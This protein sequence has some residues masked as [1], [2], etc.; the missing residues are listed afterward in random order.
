MLLI[1][2]YN[3]FVEGGATGSVDYQVKFY[4]VPEHCNL[5]EML[6]KEPTVTYKNDVGEMVEWRFA[7]LVATEWE[8]KFESGEEVLGFI[9]GKPELAK[10]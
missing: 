6:V 9:T 3:C 5:A 2:C 8:P 10:E 1:A 4:D 7:E